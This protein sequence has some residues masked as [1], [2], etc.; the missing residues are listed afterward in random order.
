MFAITNNVGIRIV[1]RWECQ[2]LIDKGRCDNWFIWECECDK[3]FD[4][5]QYL[6]YKNY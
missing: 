3:S 1:C 2:E 5:G 4:I 6:G